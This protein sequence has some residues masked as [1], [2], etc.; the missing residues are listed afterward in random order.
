MHPTTMNAVILASA[1]VLAACGG[2][3]AKSDETQ[4]P[5]VQ[6]E[7]NS[8]GDADDYL[9]RLPQDEI[10]YFVIPD[11]FENADTSND[12]GGFEGGRLDHG[13]DPTA[14]GFY[15]G[16]DLKGLTSRLDYI[17]GLGATAIWLGPIYKNKPVQGPPGDESSGYHGYWITDFTA[18]DPHLGSKE[19]LKAFVDGAHARGMKVYLD[20]ITNHTADVIKMRECADPD[21][22]EQVES[23]CPYRSLADYPYT[24]RGGVDGEAI[25][26]GFQGDR[27]PFQT[28]ENFEKLV[29]NDFAYTPFV[30]EGEEGS[31][32]P[33]WLN[34]IRYYHNRGDTT[35]EGES[36]LYGDFVGLDDLMTEDPFVVRGFIDIYKNWISEYR[37]DGFRIDTARH[38]NP[39]FWRAFNPAMIEHGESVGIPNFYVFGEVYNPDPGG[40]ARFTRV[41]SFPTVLDFGFQSAAYDVLV[42]GE[43]T[44]RFDRLF[45]ADSLYTEGAADIAPTFLGNHDMGRF[46]GFLRQNS[47]DMSDD[48]IFRRIRLG[49]ALIMFARGVPVIYYGDEQGFVSDGNDQLARENMFPSQVAVYNDNDLIATDAT[50]AESNFDTDHP[51][52]RAIAE[53]AALYH[54]HELLRRGKQVMRLTELDG[55]AMVF[56]RIDEEGREAVIVMNFG[57]EARQVN[58]LVDPRSN[59]FTALLGDCPT[60]VAAEG[61]ISANIGPLDYMVCLSNQWDML[62]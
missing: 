21:W 48:E 2:A 17:K 19:D 25:N 37:M 3:N 15:N 46:A 52:Y 8:G 11:R 13:F 6:V 59:A 5:S 51:L 62:Q 24:T 16:G 50:T 56:S 23:G 32:T 33:G 41:D 36:S 26:D 10:I 1:L 14:K 47:P 18:P 44:S 20:I 31:K 39:E 4:P 22:P 53:M 28:E 58:A 55:G 7:P 27:E 9:S 49:H 60:G 45:D 38:V 29:R 35:F 42:K 34:D 30:P 43:S 61:V 54:D 57:N 12:T 40:L